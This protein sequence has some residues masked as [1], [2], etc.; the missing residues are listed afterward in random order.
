MAQWP[1]KGVVRMP[2]GFRCVPL[3]AALAFFSLGCS[4]RSSSVRALAPGD[5]RQLYAQAVPAIYFVP[6]DYTAVVLKGDHGDGPRA[7]DNERK[8]FSHVVA[9]A[10]LA[11]DDAKA[12]GSAVLVTGSNNPYDGEV[13]DK[14]KV[15][16]QYS[17]A[18]PANAVVV[19][20]RYLVSDNVSGAG[21]A[22]LG[23]MLG[24]T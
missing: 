8:W 24:S 4:G 3:L 18:V 1:K 6:F 19:M 14:L 9:G 11:L 15:L 10:Q 2:L 21:R 17:P 13:M 5:T 7:A 23:A 16:F 12:G 20:G 22:M